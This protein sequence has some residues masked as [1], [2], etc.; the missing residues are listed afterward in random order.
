MPRVPNL[1]DERPRELRAFPITIDDGE[2]VVVHAGAPQ[3][4]PVGIGQLVAW[5]EGVGPQGS[6]DLRGAERV[7]VIGLVSKHVDPHPP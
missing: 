1:L 4:V 2:H 3:V 6:T 7:F 5:A